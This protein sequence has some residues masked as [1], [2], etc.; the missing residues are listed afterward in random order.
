MNQLDEKE[1]KHGTCYQKYTD[2]FGKIYRASWKSGYISRYKRHSDGMFVAL[3]VLNNSQNVSLEFI[4]EYMRFI[5]YSIFHL[6]LEKFYIKD[7]IHRDLKAAQMQTHQIEHMQKI[8]QEWL[9]DFVRSRKI[10]N[11]SSTDDSSLTNIIHPEAVYKSS[12]L[13]FKNLSELKNSDNYYEM[14]FI[15]TANHLQEV[16]KSDCN[17]LINLRTKV[18]LIHQ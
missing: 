2:G 4:N 7:L 3:K 13:S 8:F 9:K 18:R 6:G 12:P 15:L 14:L 16:S 10:N 5:F 11:V 1:P 17:D